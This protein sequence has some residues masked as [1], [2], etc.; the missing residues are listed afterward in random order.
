MRFVEEEGNLIVMGPYVT[1]LLGARGCA[2]IPVILNDEV[3][4]V[5]FARRLRGH[6]TL[7]APVLFPAVPQGS[8][9]LRLGVT[10]AQ[11]TGE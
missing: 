4:T 1:G 3:T 6:G 7:V 10:A 9:R 8:T 5:L 2:F 11:E